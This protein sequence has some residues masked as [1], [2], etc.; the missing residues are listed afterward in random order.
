MSK[1]LVVIVRP[2][3]LESDWVSKEVEECMA[4]RRTPIA[5]DVNH[6]LES[7]DDEIPVKSRL[8]DKLFLSETKPHK[9]PKETPENSPK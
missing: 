2:K 9:P 1:K 7:A 5:I 8:Q 6:T 4:A 3:A